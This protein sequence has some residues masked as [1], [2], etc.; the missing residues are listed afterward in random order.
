MEDKL[1][2]S[3]LYLQKLGPDHLQ[4]IFE[5][6][7]WLFEQDRSMA[8]QI[9]TSEDVE[10]PRSSVA[11]YLEGIDPQLCIRYLE[12]LIQERQEESTLFHDR[13]AE[14]Y[15]KTT[16]S[17]RKRN[18]KD[19][20]QHYDKL[21]KFIETTDRY[22]IDRLYSHLSSEDLFEARAI[23]LGRFGRHDQALELY[24]YRLQ[25]FLKAEQH[26]IRAYVAGSD[27]SNVFL[28]LLRIYLQPTSKT[29]ADLLQP[30][31]ELIARHS[32]QL[33]SV[34]TLQLLPPLVTTQDVRTFLV[35]ALRAP[36]FDTRVVRNLSKA[37]GDQVD[38]KLMA[39]QTRRVKVT[40]SRIC[41]QCHKRI[42]N[43]F[44]AVH[45]PR[46]EVTHYQC[47]EAFSRKLNETR[48]W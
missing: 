40:D 15:L 46:G 38:C 29:T 32:H 17:A 22:R 24:V 20:S 30:A 14:L 12:F 13:L 31:L 42:G 44:I 9:F 39:L 45:S 6:G 28:T 18:E 16:L 47:R 26:C 5:S 27:T 11:D 34:A 35:G 36:I 3:I 25:D 48:R 2:P 8:F 41:P 23:L 37:R 1:A 10:L 43:S 33:D 19:W 4:E 7:R 21:L